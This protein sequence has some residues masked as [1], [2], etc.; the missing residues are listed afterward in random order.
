M[1]IQSRTWMQASLGKVIGPSF[2]AADMPD[3]VGRLIDVYL[4]RRH[5]DGRRTR[6]HFVTFPLIASVAAGILTFEITNG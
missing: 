2:A 6:T 5:E 4:Q 3:V 1:A